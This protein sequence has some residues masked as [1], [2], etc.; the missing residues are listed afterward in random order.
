MCLR[1]REG[2]R[3]GE[4]ERERMGAG[5]R[6][7][8]ES[9]SQIL[10]FIIVGQKYCIISIIMNASQRANGCLMLLMLDAPH[11]LHACTH[12]TPPRAHTHTR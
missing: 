2:E 12:G 5:A 9:L 7:E 4:R 10:L 1:G 8:C 11:A 6:G 3:E